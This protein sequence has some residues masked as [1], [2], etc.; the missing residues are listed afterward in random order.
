MEDQPDMPFYQL[1]L[2]LQAGAMQQMGKIASPFTGKIERDLDMVRSTIDLL[3]MLQRKTAGNLNADEKQVLDHVLY[4]LRLNFIDEQG[5]DEAAGS[6][7]GD[8]DPANTD[9]PGEEK[10]KND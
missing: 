10:E 1:V 2:S 8:A 3:D 9:S 7:P 6:A 5:K 4:E